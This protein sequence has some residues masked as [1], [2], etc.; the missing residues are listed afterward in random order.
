MHKLLGCARLAAPLGFDERCGPTD[1]SA[2]IGLKENPQLLWDSMKTAANENLLQG[3]R[4]GVLSTQVSSVFA[5]SQVLFAPLRARKEGLCPQSRVHNR[6]VR[7]SSHRKGSASGARR[8]SR[9]VRA[10]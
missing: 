4:R 6:R 9:V 3:L 10:A 2:G 1:V 8:S 7:A 5:P